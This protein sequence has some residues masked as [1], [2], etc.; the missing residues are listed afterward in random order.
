M[1]ML[2]NI[3]MPT[4]QNND[5]AA[6]NELSAARVRRFASYFKSYMGLSSIVTAAL[7]IPVTAGNLI[8]AFLSQRG[9]LATFAALYCFLAFGFVFYIRHWLA[10]A[11]F[12]GR[13]AYALP[14]AFIFSS[15][16]SFGVYDTLVMQEVRQLKQQAEAQHITLSSKEILEHTEAD[17][18][19]RELPLVAA[20]VIAY[21][22]AE[23]AFVT[24]A[25]REYM[26]DVL[27][28]DDAQLY[29][30]KGTHVPVAAV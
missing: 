16:V 6:V 21:L 11:M 19:H 22:F 26:Q 2:G 14:V 15:L 10:R 4:A 29:E 30:G 24:M 1:R 23:L 13:F 8:P 9:S 27:R 17:Q 3:R 7:P 20:Y 28:I 18:I 25:V 5:P 12:R